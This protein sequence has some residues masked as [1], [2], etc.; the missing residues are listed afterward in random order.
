MDVVYKIENL[1]ND[2]TFM[3][4]GN[5][6]MT[7][8]FTKNIICDLHMGSFIEVEKGLEELCQTVNLQTL[9]KNTENKFWEH[10]V[11]F[12]N[13]LAKEKFGFFTTMPQYFPPISTAWEDSEI[14][15]NAIVRYD[16]NQP[17]SLS[18]T[19]QKLSDALC[20]YIVLD[21]RSL[22]SLEQL[23]EVL[24]EITFSNLSSVELYLKYPNEIDTEEILSLIAN[25]IK[26]I[27]VTLYGAEKDEVIKMDHN[28]MLTYMMSSADLFDH[29]G[30]V[31]ASFFNTRNSHFL[32]SQHKN[33]CLNKKLTIDTDGN[34]KSCPV[35]P[36]VFGNIKDAD[37]R[38]LVNRPEIQQLWNIKKDEIDT[39]KDCEYRHICTDCR[40]HIVDPENVYSKPA[41]CNY[42]PYTGNWEN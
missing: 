30:A 40:G 37:I 11:K 26:I 6:I 8:G 13:K 2:Y 42:D 24:K 18:T 39:C 4:F 36:Q 41:K 31:E 10:I 19:F 5:C 22:R 27:S 32:E 29:C 21:I 38:E 35:M 12:Y 23:K 16:G 20:F 14:V 28:V 1:D 17:R 34:I 25:R 7:K 9:K 3:L 33:T 15:T